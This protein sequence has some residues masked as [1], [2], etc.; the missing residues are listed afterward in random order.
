M[1]E[2]TELRKIVTAYQVPGTTIKVAVNDRGM[3]GI[4]LAELRPEDEHYWPVEPDALMQVLEQARVDSHRIM[5]ARAPSPERPHAAHILAELGA[6][7]PLST[8]ELA[9]RLGLEFNTVHS[10]LLRLRNDGKLHG[11][12]GRWD[13]ENRLTRLCQLA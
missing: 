6:A 13:L 12:R 5:Q 3:V 9:D 7:G 1:T 2:H 11:L 10:E 4:G 8:K